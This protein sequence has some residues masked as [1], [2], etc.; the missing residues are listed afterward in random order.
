MCHECVASETA[1]AGNEKIALD[2]HPV[3]GNAI[4]VLMMNQAVVPG[5]CLWAP[6]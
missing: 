3:T 4:L 6:R 1:V 5:L 2:P